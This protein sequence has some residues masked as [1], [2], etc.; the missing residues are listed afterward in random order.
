MIR[1]ADRAFVMLV[2]IALASSAILVS[3]FVS[4]L[5]HVPRLFAGDG[6]LFGDAVP[7]LILCLATIGFAL[8]LT[9]LARQLWETLQ[10][11]RGLLRRR[12]P[13][14][15]AVARLARELGIGERLDVVANDRPFAFT[16]WF[17]RP[18]VCVSTGLLR[19]LDRDELRAVLSH[20][21]YHLERRDPLRIVLARYFAAG[22]YVVPVVDDLVAHYD[23]LK[24][25]AADED[26]VR[27][28]GSVRPLA[29]ALYRLMPHADE[30]DLGLLAPVG[31]LTVTE[32]RIDQLVEP[33]PIAARLPLGHVALSATTLLGA[34]ALLLAQ[35][36][37]AAGRLDV[38]LPWPPAVV[39]SLAAIPGVA[40]QVRAFIRS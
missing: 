35:V 33:R 26:A 18:R 32:A 4:L 6:D 30:M 25:V 2:G 38:A 12:V 31:G 5:P 17:V 1:T 10:L 29:R 34:L 37:L 23:M 24:E 22:L 20:E 11:I 21:R 39:I 8:G 3:L 14:A 9:A 40:H 7:A 19:R 16:Y 27:A 13:A 28:M 15:A 36:P